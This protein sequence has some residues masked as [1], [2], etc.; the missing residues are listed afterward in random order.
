M[1]DCKVVDW[2]IGQ[3]QQVG[4]QPFFMAVG[5][6]PPHMPMYAPRK[7]FDQFPT[8]TA[9]LPQVKL[10]DL[11]DVPP[12]GVGLAFAMDRHATITRNGKWRE[13][14][15]AYLA[16]IAFADAMIGRLLNAL[17][18]SP[19]ANNTV[20]M[21]VG[22]NGWHL[23]QKQH[24]EKWT[25]W[26]EATQVPMIISA[27]WLNTPGQRCPR[28]VSLSTSIQRSSRSAGCRPSRISRVSRST[29][30]LLANTGPTR[31]SGDHAIN[32]GKSNRAVRD[33]D[34]RYI[35]YWDGS[36]ELYNHAVDPHEWTNLAGNSGGVGCWTAADS[37]I[38]LP[39][40]EPEDS[41][42][43][44]GRVRWAQLSCRRSTLGRWSLIIC[45]GRRIPYPS[46]ADDQCHMHNSATVMPLAV[47]T[48]AHGCHL[49]RRKLDV[50]EGEDHH[51]LG[52]RL[53]AH[54][55]RFLQLLRDK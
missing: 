33:Q 38:H 43:P 17:D 40:E 18:R 37:P 35:R 47:E 29:A 5:L 16:C 42:R 49:V 36:E 22:D 46:R 28:P 10:N 15:A 4:S 20:V 51:T 14:V 27:P 25:L 50:A 48:P 7:Y 13:G 19:Y 45:S 44:S 9:S 32:R 34:W 52:V 6:I 39:S 30:P 11:N 54:G 26:E 1:G 2:A 31:P 21:L 24:W 53:E 23:G 55:E 8:A 3:M 12:A 41:N